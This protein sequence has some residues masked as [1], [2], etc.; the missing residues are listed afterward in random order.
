MAATLLS[1]RSRRSWRRRCCRGGWGLVVADRRV[2]ITL[3]QH[4]PIPLDVDVACDPGDVLAIFGPSG[5]GK[6]PSFARLRG[7]IARRRPW[8]DR[9]A[10]MDGYRQRA[11]A[12][13]S[14]RRWIR[15]SGVR[16]VSAFDR[17]RQRDDGAWASATCRRRTRAEALLQRVHLSDPMTRRR[18][19]VGRRASAGRARESAGARA[20]RPAARRTVCRGRSCGAARLQDEIDALRRTLDMPLSSSRTISKM[21]SGWPRTS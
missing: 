8:S 13:P 14:P 10:D 11:F 5:S 1:W 2:T 9:A 19:V 6:Q 18:R 3:R 15:L 21:S 7:S 20:G 4:S 12:P 16:A 17:G